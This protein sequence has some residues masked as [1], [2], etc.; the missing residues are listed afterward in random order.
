MP[1]GPE[2]KSAA[3]AVI[4]ACPDCGA[5]NRIPRER[6]AER[7]KCGRCGR[8]LGP[9]S[10]SSSTSSSS[11]RS[12]PA[13]ASARREDRGSHAAGG[14]TYA[15]GELIGGRYQVQD[16]FG[17]EGKSSMGIVYK[18]YDREHSRIIA[19]K[20]L[21]QKFL[22]SP[23]IVDS[24]RKEALAWIYLE[25]HP[26]IV[27]AYWARDIDHQIFIACEFILPDSAGRNS[28]TPYLTAPFSL[29]RS[30]R[31]A[32]QFCH[33]MEYACSRGVTPH[34]DVKPDNIMITMDGDVKITDFGLV[35]LWNKSAQKEGIT[36]LLAKNR[37]DLAFLNADNSRMIA[38]SPAWM[39]PEQ[40]Y[41]VA[42][43]S[44]DIYSFGIVLFQ[45]VNN[46]QLPF[47]LKSGDSWRTAH[48]DYPLPRV[49]SQGRPLEAVLQA[50]LQKRRD[51][52]Y[53]DFGALR[54]EL[55]HIFRREITRHTGEEPPAAPEHETLK[56]ADLINRGLSLT[57]LGLVEE[58]IRNYRE[59]IRSNPDDANAHYNL[60]NALA[61]KGQLAEAIRSYRQ[62]IRIDPDHTAGH[63]NLGIALFRSGKVDEAIAEYRE[64][65]RTDMVF[66]AAYVNLGVALAKKGLSDEALQAYDDAVRVQPQFAEA[67]HK[68]GTALFSSGRIDEALPA[69]RTAAELQ[70]DHAEAQA[71]LGTALARM[72][73]LDDAISAYGKAVQLRPDYADA[74]YNLGSAFLLKEMHREALYAF[75]E[76]VR[77]A[78]P[79]D[80]RREKARE[81]IG[82]LK[83][84]LMK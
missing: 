6:L 17:G 9:A 84:A 41:G 33:G 13:T 65:L 12:S 5:K 25:K 31:W 43:V 75:E 64:A 57:N 71:N 42:E 39:A 54:S 63:Y 34:R 4:V 78:A 11:L 16:V 7:P 81:L 56:G 40:F 59:S 48:K 66:G 19:L 38:G 83:D 68:L 18:C 67:W 77:Q 14:R 21:Q 58:G 47:R 3:A 69:L 20:T 37:D 52:R 2:N 29:Q 45:M 82:K 23:R 49:P 32:I 8:S 28:L 1:G 15:A 76:Y 26:H 62:A 27:R 24:F 70:P 44:S 30:L 61:Q 51:R 55:E 72:G 53:R 46:G 22:G 10:G 35:G 80:G 74:Y 79:G 36:G 73:Q 60:G 50:C